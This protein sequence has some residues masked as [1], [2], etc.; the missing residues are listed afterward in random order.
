MTGPYMVMC[1]PNFQ[2]LVCWSTFLPVVCPSTTLLCHDQ[3]ENPGV[4]GVK[5]NDS[6]LRWMCIGRVKG[7]RT[8]HISMTYLFRDQ[9]TLP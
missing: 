7:I 5:T 8:V 9:I 3:A 2:G 4:R 1:D 6:V